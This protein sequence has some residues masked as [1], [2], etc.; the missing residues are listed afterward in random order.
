MVDTDTATGAC[1]RVQRDCAWRLLMRRT[2]PL[3]LVVA[4]AA[5]SR[6]VC[7]HVLWSAGYATIGRQT[8]RAAQRHIAMDQPDVVLCAICVV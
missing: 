6:A 8:A 2:P 5:A 1:L 3:I 7:D 4:Q